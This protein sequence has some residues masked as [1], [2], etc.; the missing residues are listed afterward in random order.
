MPPGAAARDTPPQGAGAQLLRPLPTVH[1]EVCSGGAHHRGV[2]RAL[3]LFSL[4]T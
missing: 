1:P 4:E 2:T 3:V